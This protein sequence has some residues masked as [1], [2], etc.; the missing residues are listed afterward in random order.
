[1]KSICLLD[2]QKAL[3][4]FYFNG[5]SLLTKYQKGSK[6]HGNNCAENIKA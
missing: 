1:M 5:Q 3:K 4:L 2:D 6:F